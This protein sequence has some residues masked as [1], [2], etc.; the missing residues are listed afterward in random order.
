MPLPEPRS[1]SAALV[2]GASSGVGALT[3]IAGLGLE[4]DILAN[5][6]GFGMTGPFHEHDNGQAVRMVATNIEAVADLEDVLDRTPAFLTATAAECAAAGLD[7]LDAGR[8]V[9]IPRPAVRALGV[10][11]AYIPHRVGLPMWRRVFSA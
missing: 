9:V 5:C 6:A 8:R 7:G 2:T 4:I 10:I 3:A 1:G 11:G